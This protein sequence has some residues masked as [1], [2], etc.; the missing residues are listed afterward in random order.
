MPSFTHCTLGSNRAEYNTY[1]GGV[2]CSFSLPVFTNTIIAFSQGQG[3]FFHN[4]RTSQFEYCDIF[5]NSGGN[6]ANPSHGPPGIGQ[7]V[8]T[9]ANGDSCDQ[10]FNIFLDP[11][12]V[13]MAEGDYHLLAGSPCIDA[14]DPTLPHDPDGTIADIGAYY[15]DQSAVE[16]I[17]TSLPMAYAL[18]PNWPNPFNSTTMIRYDV[19]QAGQLSLTIYNLLGQRV[20]TPFDGRQLAGTYTVA[21]DAANLPSGLYFCRM[22]AAGFAQTKKMMLVK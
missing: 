3:V 9:N 4:S 6:I 19:P 21:W 15:Y 12:F 20:A 10:Y 17:V 18:H 22:D 11:M 8:G 5:G 16:P 1:G 7:I 14:G 13:D 2:Y